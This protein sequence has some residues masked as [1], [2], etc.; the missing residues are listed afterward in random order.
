MVSCKSI[1]RAY[2]GNHHVKSSRSFWCSKHRSQHQLQSSTALLATQSPSLLLLTPLCLQ[3]PALCPTP[4]WGITMCLSWTNHLTSSTL[5]QCI[6]STWLSNVL[7][8]EFAIIFIFFFLPQQQEP[9]QGGSRKAAMEEVGAQWGTGPAHP[10]HCAM[11]Q[12]FGS[13]SGFASID[14]YDLQWLVSQRGKNNLNLKSY[15]STRSIPHC[16]SPQN[17]TSSLPPRRQNEAQSGEQI[18]KQGGNSR[19]CLY[20]ECHQNILAKQHIKKTFHVLCFAP[21]LAQ[22]KVFF[23]NLSEKITVKVQGFKTH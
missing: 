20:W 8:W 6:F 2:W 1:G 14:S 13:S 22:P 10:N 3:N 7:V 16:C 21:V 4:I 17:S 9:A 5:E 12:E 18:R 23:S 15:F 11:V 19:N